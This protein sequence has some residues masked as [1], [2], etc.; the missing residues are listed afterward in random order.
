VPG[1]MR[2]SDTNLVSTIRRCLAGGRVGAKQNNI[3]LR[4][5]RELPISPEDEL[6]TEICDFLTM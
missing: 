5:F 2:R 6:M 4:I 3:Q 1:R